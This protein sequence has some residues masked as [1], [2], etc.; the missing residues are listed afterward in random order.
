MMVMRSTTPVEAEGATAVE[1][2]D[3]FARASRRQEIDLK[4]AM[5]EYEALSRN[6]D[7]TRLDKNRVLLRTHA[8]WLLFDLLNGPRSSI[9]GKH[10]CDE[11]PLTRMLLGEAGLAVTQS[12]AFAHDGFDEALDF[13]DL[14]GYPVVAKPTNLSQGRG[15]TANIKDRGE[16]SKAW[17]KASSAVWWDYKLPVRTLNIARALKRRNVGG[18]KKFWRGTTESVLVERHFDGFDYRFFVVGN[19]VISVTQR[20]PANVTGDGSSTVQELIRAKNAIRAM[21]PNLGEHLIPEN[22]EVLDSLTRA[23]LDLMHVPQN[24]ELVTLR[25]VSNL[26]A[27]G[28]SIDFTDTAH[29]AF[30]ELAIRAVKIVPG[31]E[32]A[33]VDFLAH[34]ITTAPAADNYI[35]GEVEFSPAP[36]ADF[37]IVGTPRSMAKAVLDYYL[38]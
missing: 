18:L 21:N 36:A 17:R 4:S 32:Y 26:S 11:K 14:L 6:L 16:F 34:D 29:P 24:G 23:G 8:G 15:V 7:V 3:D 33:G 1:P 25:S 9:V 31:I 12:R 30:K 13:A 10:A 5:L 35:I 22:P 37:P 20:K 2:V 38:S 19:D 27:G 28:D